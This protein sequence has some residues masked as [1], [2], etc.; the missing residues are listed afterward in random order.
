MTRKPMP[1]LLVALAAAV[2]IPGCGGGGGGVKPEPPSCIPTH[3]ETC[4]SPAEFR[5]AAAPLATNYRREE[6]VANQWGL[7]DVG[8]HWAY[9]HLELLEGEDAKPGAGVTIGFIDSGIDQNHPMFAGATLSETFLSGASDETA[10]GFA[11]NDYSHGT[12]VASIAAGR[13]TNYVDAPQGV[14]WGADIAMFAI[15]LGSGGD[16]YYVPITLAELSGRDS[17]WESLLARVLRADNDIDILNLSIGFNGIIDRY[18][19]RD[20]RNNFPETLAR[21]AQAGAGEK[22]IL[23]WAA[24]NA[25]GDECTLAAAGRHCVD[26]RLDAVSVEILPG[27]AARI[28]ELRGHTIAVVA[29]RDGASGPIIA[30]FSNR[31]GIAADYCIAAPGEE[32]WFAYFGD[33]ERGFARSRG[34]SFAAPMVAG[35]LAIMKQLFRDQLSNTELVSRLLDTAD[36]T[37]RYANRSVY[38]RGLM[39]LKV[40]TSPVGVLDVPAG[41]RAEDPGTPLQTTAVQSGAALGDGLAQSL[42]GREIAALDALG[43]P[44]WFDLDDF[45]GVASAPPTLSRLRD[46]MAPVSDSG[47]GRA[48]GFGSASGE[49]LLYRRA[50]SERW[51]FGLLEAPIGAEGGHLGLAG[52]ALALSWS[53]HGAFSGTAFTTAGEFEQAPASGAVFSWGPAGSPFGLHSGWVGERETLLGGIAAGAFGTLAAD[54]VFAGIRGDAEIGR[55]WLSADAEIGSIDPTARDG[56]VTDI[57]PLI[58]STFALRARGPLAGRGTLHLS[59][60]QPLRVERGRASLAVPVGRTKAGRIVRSRVS[61]DLAPSGRQIDIAAQWRRPLAAGELRLG[62]V[63]T[64]EPAHRAAQ[65]LEL[66]LLSG[67]R[68]TF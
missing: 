39:D 50:L 7:A 23:V 55:W 20:L 51:Q 35:G 5:T 37:G 60:S 44:F 12:A 17:H 58:T 59:V 61:A 45:V 41:S 11:A 42:A 48:D 53:D 66:T 38:G 16:R 25:H 2:V 47:R 1:V 43:A 40:A 56:F 68:W 54:A 52:R 46:L 31:C 57:S 3:S 21:L 49:H 65:D 22:T 18:S 27:L 32:V 62:A 29:V 10:A 14:A 15:P 4:L 19:A 9:A 8:A 30:D 67:W 26:G 63:V 64:H 36:N 33:Q 28:P 24:G 34:T 6:N 13:P